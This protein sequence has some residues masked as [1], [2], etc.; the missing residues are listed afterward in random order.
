ML[1]LMKKDAEN[2]CPLKK[3]NKKDSRRSLLQQDV[4][5]SR[6]AAVLQGTEIQTG[7]RK[8]NDCQAW[9]AS[10]QITEILKK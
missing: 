1:H 6:P 8:A 9:F 4:P 5:K 7:V 3:R 2:A 10:M